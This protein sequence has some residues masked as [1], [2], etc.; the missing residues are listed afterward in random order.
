MAPDPLPAA[1]ISYGDG[2][3]CDFHVSGRIAQ[4]DIAEFKR[5]VIIPDTAEPRIW[6]LCLNS[7]EGGNFDASIKMIDHM[8]GQGGAAKGIGTRVEANSRCFSA[9]ALVFLAGRRLLGDDDFETVRQLHPTSSLGFHQ[10]HFR[11]DVV[12]TDLTQ[13]YRAYE[14]GVTAIARLLT[15]DAAIFPKSLLAEFLKRRSGESFDISTIDDIG[16]WRI[17]LYDYDEPK[18]ENTTQVYRFCSNAD[19]W[20]TGQPSLDPI[21]LPRDLLGTPK[22]LRSLLNK[23]TA[24]K[25]GKNEFIFPGFGSVYEQQCIVSILDHEATLVT[26][27]GQSNLVLHADFVTETISTGFWAL[28]SPKTPIRSLQK[29]M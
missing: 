29:R 10:P 23:K 22:K 3:F 26:K 6:W 8:L 16:R 27:S 20:R 5:K 19:G 21:E 11:E 15:Y 28:L 24:I 12:A 13:L 2:K 9:C 14:A 1:E 7:E 17:G 25:V 18:L 4:T